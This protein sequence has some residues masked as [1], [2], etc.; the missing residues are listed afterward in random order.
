[1]AQVLIALAVIAIAATIAFAL[2]RRR[3]VEPPT[4]PTFETPAQL[5]RSDFERPDAP[6]LVAVFT[7]A[8]CDACALVAAKAEALASRDVA[9]QLLPYQS[10]RALHERYRIDAVPALVLADADGVV[11][12]AALGPITATDLW[13]EVAKARDAAS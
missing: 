11:R 10:E 1:M 2:R 8:S 5:D 6:W 9:V 7:S 3:E 4:Q 12:Y 13:S